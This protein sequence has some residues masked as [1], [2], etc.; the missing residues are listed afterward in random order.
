MFPR[1][2]FPSA[3]SFYYLTSQTHPRTLLT[4]KRLL[5]G[6]AIKVTRVAHPPENLS[7]WPDPADAKQYSAT[8]KAVGEGAEHGQRPSYLVVDT[9]PRGTLVVQIDAQARFA[10]ANRVVVIEDRTYAPA[11][12]IVIE[13]V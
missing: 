12:L 11:E 1:A 5:E 7:R 10:I 3:G 9:G 13:V 8:V 4:L 6:R 2:S